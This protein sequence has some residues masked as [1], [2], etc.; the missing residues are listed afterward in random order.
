MDEERRKKERLPLHLPLQVKLSSGELIQMELVDVSAEGLRVRGDA[1]SILV[2]E[3]QSNG[4][5]VVFEVRISARLAWVAPHQEGD[6]ELGL[7]L[8]TE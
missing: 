4:K 5:D 6:F 8:I 1:L 3:A 7:K 2:S